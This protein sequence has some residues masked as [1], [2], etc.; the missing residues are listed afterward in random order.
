MRGCADVAG[1]GARRDRWIDGGGAGGSYSPAPGGAK[2]EG[3]DSRAGRRADRPGA[4]VYEVGRSLAAP[5]SDYD[6]R[7]AADQ[8][9]AAEDGRDGDGAGLLVL[10][11]EGADLGVLMFVGEAEAADCEADDAE[12][13]EEDADDG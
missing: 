5:C 9:D 2:G 11:V 3:V 7:N 4:G 12:D 1:G 8:G 6:E 13:D 10:D